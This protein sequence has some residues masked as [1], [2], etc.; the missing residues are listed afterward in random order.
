MAVM[1]TVDVYRITDQLDDVTLDVL[2]TR[3][4]ARGQHPRSVPANSGHA[5]RKR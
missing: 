2:V 4:E 1:G 3:L 5:P